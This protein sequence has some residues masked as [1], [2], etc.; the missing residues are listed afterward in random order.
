MS[1]ISHR[2]GSDRIALTIGATVLAWAGLLVHNLVD[3]PG[4]TPLSP[5]SLL[6]T[7]VTVTLLVLWLVPATRTVATWALLAWSVL[8]LIGSLRE[9]DPK[10]PIIVLTAQ[11]VSGV[12]DEQDIADAVKRYD[13][14]FSEK[15]VRTSIL[16]A[17]LTRLFTGDR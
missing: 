4:Q 14:V 3:L 5:E 7:L 16:I 8:N 9:Q 12:V 15:P 2:T 1:T 6:P 10:C 11:V 17:T 13:L